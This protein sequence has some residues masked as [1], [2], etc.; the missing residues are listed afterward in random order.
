M[1]ARHA[2]PCVAIDAR[3]IRHSGIGVFLTEV[4]RS[5]AAHPPPFDLRLYGD[6]VLLQDVI[7]P[8][9]NAEASLWNPRVYSISAGLLGPSIPKGVSA[10]YS[11]HYA[12]CLRVGLPLVCHVQD[13]LHHSHPSKTGHR[14]YS[15]L[16]LRLLQSNAAFVLTTS[17]HVKVQLQTLYGFDAH[18]VLCTGAG[19]GIIEAHLDSQAP[20]P[21]ELEG[22]QYL[23]AVGIYKP[24]KNWEF[25]LE[26][27]AGMKDVTLPL[28]CAGLGA[29]AAR[30]KALA[31]RLQIPNEL[32]ILPPLTPE[33]LT[34]VY[35]GSRGLLFPSIA[36]GFGLPVLEAMATGT[37]VIIADRS[38][39]KE[40]ADG[41]GYTFQP[42]YPESFD[43]ALR[44]LLNDEPLRRRRIEAGLRRARQSSW[45]HTAGHIQDAIM[46]TITGELPPPRLD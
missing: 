34:T 45:S 36:E 21:R 37:P 31:E 43:L 17:R 44:S 5:W 24:H 25:L 27:L 10:W 11:P 4:L 35:R 16:Y 2:K 6:P 9:L 33:E 12:T 39:M 13:V 20:L 22:R 14:F 42:D 40:I 30:L 46:R 3:M 18:K 41:C 32:I 19:P 28:A 1:H 26:R 38:P 23:L 15:R 29:N 7:P 8:G